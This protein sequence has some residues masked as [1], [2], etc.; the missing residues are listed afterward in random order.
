VK[1]LFRRHLYSNSTGLKKSG[2]DVWNT[3]PS[4]IFGTQLSLLDVGGF[5]QKFLEVGGFFQK[6]SGSW[7][8][9]QCDKGIQDRV[10]SII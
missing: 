1:V 3:L 7:D 9:L 5:F 6:T 10:R 4:P 8:Q 2:Q